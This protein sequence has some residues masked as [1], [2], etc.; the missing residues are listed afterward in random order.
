MTEEQIKFQR[1]FIDVVRES[2]SLDESMCRKV[3]AEWSS[4]LD[5]VET[6][7]KGMDAQAGQIDVLV[8]END[9]LEA[10]LRR[11]M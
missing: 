9:K 3:A 4:A 10:R 5:S 7:L 2:S 1:G 6:L 11:L 8:K